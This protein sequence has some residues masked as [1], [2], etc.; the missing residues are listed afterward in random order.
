MWQ[1]KQKINLYTDEFRP[2]KL[3]QELVWL[4]SGVAAVLVL[5]IVITLSIF[6]YKKYLTSEVASAQLKQVDLTEQLD[7]LSKQLARLKVDPLLQSKIQREESQI[8]QRQQVLAFLQQEKFAEG[9]SFA[10]LADQLSASKGVW[11]QSFK[12]Y[13]DGEHIELSGFSQKPKYITQYIE[14]L[15]DKKAYQGR[16]FRQISIS[17]VEGKTY[18]QFVIATEENDAEVSD[19]AQFSLMGGVQ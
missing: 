11:L 13:E 16:S 7:E 15:S 17:E 14:S 6:S 8:R 5:S 1:I 3:P 9:I 10:A 12:F 4:A 19:N 18:S 2:P